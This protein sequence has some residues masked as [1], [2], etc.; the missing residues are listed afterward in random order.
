MG[1][2]TLLA[3]KAV[4]YSAPS[5]DAFQ[6]YNASSSGISLEDRRF[7]D[8]MYADE[9]DQTARLSGLNLFD[10]MDSAY[11]EPMRPD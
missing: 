4:A 11:E 8:E 1:L 10:W 6:M 2:P 9:I 7:L 3:P 5:G